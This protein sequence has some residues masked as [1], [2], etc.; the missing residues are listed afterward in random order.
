[1]RYVSS[2]VIIN[3]ALFF[4]AAAN[5][6][7]FTFHSSLFF[8]NFAAAKLIKKTEMTNN[9]LTNIILAGIAILLAVLCLVSILGA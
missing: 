3:N 7:L 2:S 8:I 1:M 9:R 4:T 5:Y 6:S